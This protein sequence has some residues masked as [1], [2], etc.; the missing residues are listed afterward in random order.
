MH[1]WSVRLLVVLQCRKLFVEIAHDLPDSLLFCGLPVIKLE[2][3]VIIN[4]FVVL[5][6]LTALDSDFVIRVFVDV[7]ECEIAVTRPRNLVTDAATP[8]AHEHVAVNKPVEI[9]SVGF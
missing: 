1:N 6:F 9:L 4:S 7:V 8:E 3:F 2:L 5:D